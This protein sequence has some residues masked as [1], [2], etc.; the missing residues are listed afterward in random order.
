MR[1][2]RCHHRPLGTPLTSVERAPSGS[3]TGHS[4]GARSGLD[5]GRGPALNS[6]RR[7]HDSEVSAHQ[8]RRTLENPLAI[9]VL[10]VATREPGQRPSTEKVRNELRGEYSGM[11][12]RQVAF[13]LGPLRDVDRLP[14]PIAEG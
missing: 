8:V 7:R 9:R 12:V 2:E 5:G 13:H 11:Q 3:S 1:V 4:C 14:S 6:R 10:E